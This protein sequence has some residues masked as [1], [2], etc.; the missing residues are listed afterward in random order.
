M[1]TRI[2]ASAVIKKDG[3]LLFGKKPQHMEPYPNTWHL[4]GAAYIRENQ[5]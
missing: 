4:L 2:I 3:K 5:S 1:E